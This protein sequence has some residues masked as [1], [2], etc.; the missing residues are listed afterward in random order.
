[1]EFSKK[2]IVAFAGLMI[3]IALINS[4]AFGSYITDFFVRNDFT[5]D[6]AKD[7]VVG[8][9]I[10]HKFGTG[11]VGTSL[12]P[13][14][15]SG[16]YRNPTAAVSLEFVSDDV[17]DNSA[18]N[19][20]REITYFCLD[21]SWLEVTGT[22]ATNGTTAV[23]LGDDCI[24]LHRWFVSSSGA[25]ATQTT[26]SHEGNLTIRVAGAG[27][28][29]ST[30][31]NTPLAIGQSQIGSYTIP[32]GKTGYLLGKTVFTD[33]A[34]VADVYFFQRPNAD[35]VTVPYS[36]I[37][38]IVER[39]VGVT[40]GFSHHFA[41]AK[42]GIVGPADIGF[43]AKVSSGTAEVSVEFELLIVDN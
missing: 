4:T 17:D 11:T 26:G 39:E 19:G 18:G 34:K 13:V 37:L 28:V 33:T 40:G 15:Q 9:V 10:V 29:W 14:T 27:D 12:V 25:Y 16:F 2:A 6:I 21:S 22:V 8:E 38:K 3:A 32:A 42:T 36:G 20:A 23:A 43:M 1:M 24:R 35:D 41:I 31:P 7:D 5:F 30:I